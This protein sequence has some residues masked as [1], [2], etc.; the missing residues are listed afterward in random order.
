MKIVP[1]PDS[2]VQ[3]PCEVVG[4]GDTVDDL[5]R[6]YVLNTSCVGEYKI[7]VDGLIKYNNTLKG[8]V[9]GE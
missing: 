9:D 7:T 6:G 2:L 3:H 5:I 1:L 4:P 8:M